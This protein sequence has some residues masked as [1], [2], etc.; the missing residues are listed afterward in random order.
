[1]PIPSCPA[2]RRARPTAWPAASTPR[3]SESACSPATGLLADI[4]AADAPYRVALRA[5]MDALPVRERTGLD[6]SSRSPGV[7]HACGH[8][9]HVAALLGA[10]LA[11]KECEPALVERGIAVRGIFQAA[12]EIMPGGAHDA[13]SAGAVDGVHAV[14]ADPLRPEPRHRRGRPARRAADGGLRPGHRLA[15]RQGRAH[16]ASPADR[17]PHLRP[18]QGRHRR[19]GRA[20]APARP[21]GRG[22]ARLGH[23]QR[24]AGARTSSRPPVSAAGPCAC[25]TPRPG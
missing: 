1:M 20:L 3:A 8:D 2:R 10:L 4:G 7:C 17:G 12:E 6:F 15:P 13:I 25:S 19:A 18:R 9:V 5:D 22:R 24:R 21:A 16:V 11:L 14:F 23:D